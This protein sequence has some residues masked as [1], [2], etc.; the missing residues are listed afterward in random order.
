MFILERVQ[1]IGVLPRR[2][3][4]IDIA[5][6]AEDIT[7]EVQLVPKTWLSFKSWRS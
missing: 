2:K 1:D 4:P 6:Q 5:I 3:T 7:A